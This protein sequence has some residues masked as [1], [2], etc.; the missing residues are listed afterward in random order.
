MGHGHDQ[1]FVYTCRFIHVEAI[2]HHI[3]T[4]AQ[5]DK[6]DCT[7]FI[8]SK[9]SIYMYT[10]YL[11]LYVY[12]HVVIVH[13]I[14]W[15][16]FKILRKSGRY[17]AHPILTPPSP[18]QRRR[19]PSLAPLDMHIYIYTYTYIYIH[20][21]ILYMYLSARWV[22]HASNGVLLGL[23]QLRSF[24]LIQAPLESRGVAHGVLRAIREREDGVKVEIIDSK[25][26]GS[27]LNSTVGYESNGAMVLASSTGGCVFT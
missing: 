26:H 19:L 23:I 4:T 12:V 24:Q 6:R 10:M 21:H 9:Y 13:Q 27:H 16:G 17:P 20:T 15:Y 3:Y 18:L 11:Y 2:C 22:E 5:V 8:V 25:V 1:T 14:I 7:L